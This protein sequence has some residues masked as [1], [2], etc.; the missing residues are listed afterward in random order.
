MNTVLAFLGS[1]KS[2]AIP[3][4]KLVA[5]ENG[6]GGG[7]KLSEEDL[8][9]LEL[10]LS[11]HKTVKIGNAEQLRQ[12]SLAKIEAELIAVEEAKQK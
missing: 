9:K 12:E 7:H 10:G 6:D 8:G 5:R 1:P 11:Q 2:A 4:I 3:N